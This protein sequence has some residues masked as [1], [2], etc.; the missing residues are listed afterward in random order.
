MY[1]DRC[2]RHTH[3]SNFFQFSSFHESKTFKGLFYPRF[4]QLCQALCVSDAIYW[5]SRLHSGLKQCWFA[6][7]LW[8]QPVLFLPSVT[9]YFCLR[10]YSGFLAGPQG[11]AAGRSRVKT[12][13]WT[14]IR[15]KTR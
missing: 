1:Q 4:L 14:L 15:I 8:D 10:Q 12:F 11:R 13:F 6:L 7:R 5:T 2:P 9:D 3:T